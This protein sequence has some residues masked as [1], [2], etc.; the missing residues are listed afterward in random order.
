MHFCQKQGWNYFVQE[1]TR[2]RI[3]PK[4]YANNFKHSP[5]KLRIFHTK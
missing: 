3:P 1:P 2:A 4:S 5:G